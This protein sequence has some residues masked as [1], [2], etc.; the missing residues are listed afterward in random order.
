MGGKVLQRL[1]D[2]TACWIAARGKDSWVSRLR[3]VSRNENDWMNRLMTPLVPTKEAR[4][5]VLDR[6]EPA[7]ATVTGVAFQQ[8]QCLP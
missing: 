3:A 8:S 6:G 5:D 7:P 1:R 2:D 4:E